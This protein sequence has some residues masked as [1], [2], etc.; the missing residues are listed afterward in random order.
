MEKLFI[1]K[2]LTFFA[3]IFFF[4]C[5]KRID[6]K[7]LSPIEAS[8]HATLEMKM[9]Q[10]DFANLNWRNA[11]IKTLNGDD[12][13]VEIPTFSNSS[14]K[15]IYSKDGQKEVYNYYEIQISKINKIQGSGSLI[16]SSIDNKI[17]HEYLIINNKIVN[18]FEQTLNKVKSLSINTDDLSELFLPDVF[19][20]ATVTDN[21]GVFGNYISLYWLFDGW[22]NYVSKYADLNSDLVMDANAATTGTNYLYDA[23]STILSNGKK[24]IS[25]NFKDAFAASGLD[26]TFNIDPSTNILDETSI[27]TTPSGGGRLGSS[28]SVFV[29]AWTQIKV[30]DISYSSGNLVQFT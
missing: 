7:K 2:W 22:N 30:Q 17:L 15:L 5:T 27:V 14:K 10:K 12:F 16:L 8:A 1:K 3:I 18:S 28:V 6:E 19:V 21:V 24:Q 29:G 11:I 13:L 26:V 4:S 23:S 25:F 9:S 20:Y